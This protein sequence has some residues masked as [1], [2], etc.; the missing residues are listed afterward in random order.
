MTTSSLAEDQGVARPSQ[1]AETANASATS[2][3][4]AYSAATAVQGAPPPGRGAGRGMVIFGVVVGIA[5]VGGV[6]LALQSHGTALKDLSARIDS[7]ERRLDTAAA[8]IA[9]LPDRIA[10][11]EKAVAGLE[12]RV[13]EAAKAPDLSGIPPAVHVMAA[14]QLRAA[15]SR[16][17]PFHSELA[18]A[19]LAGAVDGEVAKVVDA[20]A[21]RAVE[22]VPTRD[23]LVARFAMLVPAVLGSELGGSP[24]GVGNA[25]WGWVTGMATVLRPSA[26]DAPGE[27]NRPAALLARAGIMLE[28]GDLAG[29]IERIALLE[30]AQAE[31]AAAWLTDARARVAADRASML[32]AGHMDEL[33]AAAKR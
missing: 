26:E 14:R 30:G 15:L 19:R 21:P 27:E 13:A 33:L 20:I 8:A 12:S 32:L 9:P 5:A 11:I 17:T 2:S 16:S 3:A 28:A 1:G 29:A 25:M 7:L 23:E 24:S 4:D 31:T 18:L 6:L 22:G 10:G